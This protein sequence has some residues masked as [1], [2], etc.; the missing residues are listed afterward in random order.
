[1]LINTLNTSK[2]TSATIQTRVK[3]AEETE[4]KINEAREVYRPV[5]IR[6]SIIYFV[7][8]DLA[9]I[10]PMYQYR[11]DGSFT[12]VGRGGGG[13][14]CWIFADACLCVCGLA[15]RRNECSTI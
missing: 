5:P 14:V 3:E 6:G 4:K 9:L 13:S 12:G 8:A 1:M 2:I 15:I 7:V 11:W 10:D